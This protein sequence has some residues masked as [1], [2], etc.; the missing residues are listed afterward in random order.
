MAL[1][2][3]IP[4][5]YDVLDRPGYYAQYDWSL[6]SQN[7]WKYTA[8]W[9]NPSYGTEF[10]YG[11]YGREGL[12]S[13][14][15]T[16]KRSL[17][18]LGSTG[19][20]TWEKMQ[21]LFKP[22]QYY[23]EE[24][25]AVRIDYTQHTVYVRMRFVVEYSQEYGE[26][27]FLFSDWSPVVGYGKDYKPY[28][29]PT[30]LEAPVISDFRLTEEMF[31]GGPIAAFTLA[32]PQS[33]KDNMAGA[34]SIDD[35]IY[36]HAEVSIGGGDWT[37]VQLE[38]RV[39]TDGEMRALL[40][41]AQGVVGEDTH[42]QLRTRY[43]YHPEVNSGRREFYSDWS[44]V[45]QFGAPAWGEASPWATDI[46]QK[47]DAMDL[48]P[49]TLKGQDLTRPITRAE[50]A[51][52]GVKVY[53]NLSGVAAI[54]A[55]NNPF[56]DTNDVEVLKAYNIGF[57]SGTAVD[58][59]SPDALLTREQAAVMLTRIFKKV[60]MPG[61]TSETD[62]QFP[63]SFVRPAPFADDAK[64]SDWAKDSVYFMFANGII[65]GMGN[66][67]FGPR[68]TTPAEQ[69]QNYASATREQALIIAVGMVE[70]L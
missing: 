14:Q 39:I 40:A 69:A 38:T 50:F 62:L 33:V 52:V 54:P 27:E 36:L 67:I 44:N 49:D 1:S 37:D 7:D 46:L 24:N 41:T 63:L 10:I 4:Q 9:D 58:K 42:V 23:V 55:V 25:G 28:E 18:D 59:F 26:Y 57:T 29:P 5:H 8:K 56:T 66:N 31:N 15:I 11:E 20:P 47:A 19:W 60:S 22:G 70:K 34:K 3:D 17:L 21:T 65:S 13:E 35:D 53:E 51:A 64:I 43:G 68:A 32:N 30:T 45:V 48:I 61:W 12:N 2:Y 6:D 16:E